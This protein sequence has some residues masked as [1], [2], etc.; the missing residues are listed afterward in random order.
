MS[1]MGMEKKAGET[2]QKLVYHVRALV[3]ILRAFNSHSTNIYCQSTI[4]H[5][6]DICKYALAKTISK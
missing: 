3:F 4:G 5:C 1:D 2:M 6:L